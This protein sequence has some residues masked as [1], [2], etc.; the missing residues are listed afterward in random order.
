MAGGSAI[1]GDTLDVFGLVSLC[2]PLA[3]IEMGDVLAMRLF[4]VGVVFAV[5]VDVLVDVL[6]VRIL[7]G[8]AVMRLLEEWGL[9]DADID[10]AGRA[11]GGLVAPGV[12]GEAERPGGAGACRACAV[13]PLGLPNR[14]SCACSSPPATEPNP[15]HGVCRA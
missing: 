15:V 2:V 13:K 3:A 4:G 9:A 10:Q 5:L 7:P 14:C 8:A 6:V 11:G 12:H 1:Y